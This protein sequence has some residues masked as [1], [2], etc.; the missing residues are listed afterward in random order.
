MCISIVGIQSAIAE[1]RRGKKRKTEEERKKPQGKK[2]NGLPYFIG[3][4]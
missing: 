4:P 1:I 3:P 2:Y